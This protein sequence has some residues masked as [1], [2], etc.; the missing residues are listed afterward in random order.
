MYLIVGEADDAVAPVF[1]P[2][3]A[4]SIVFFLHGVDV[5][6]YFDDEFVFGAVKVND[7]TVNG[8]LAAKFKA[9]KLLAPQVLPQLV[10]SGRLGL[11]QL[12][13]HAPG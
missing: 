11:A 8:M 6:V 12:D 13:G 7:E 3:G 9:T 4:G 1:E 5:S 10:F 2:F